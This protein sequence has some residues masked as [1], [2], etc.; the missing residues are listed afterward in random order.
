M[1][2]TSNL[3]GIFLTEMNVKRLLILIS[4]IKEKVLENQK[5]NLTIRIN[6]FYFSY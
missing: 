6:V 2:I 5:K 3:K 4:S 1:I